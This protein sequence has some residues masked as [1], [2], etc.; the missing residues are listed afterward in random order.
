MTHEQTPEQ[1]PRDRDPDPDTGPVRA[2][3]AALG[4]ARMPDD[5]AARI[6]A[7]LAGEHVTGIPAGRSPDRPVPPV[8]DRPAAAARP[9][10]P[11][12]VPPPGRA[13]RTR[14]GRGPA[15]AARPAGRP[16]R[17]AARA[18]AALLAAA[19]A[20]VL[21]ALPVDVRGPAPAGTTGP[22][23]DEL[24]AAAAGAGEPQGPL[25]DPVRRRGCLLAAGVAA[26]D[27]PLLAARP[28]PVAGR[29][30][31]LLVLGTP[32]R[33]EFRLVV[34]DPGCGPGRGVLLAE[35]PAGA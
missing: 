13:R 9:A 29:P 32:R 25:A 6:R 7:R 11:A 22:L 27:A 33:G 21:L 34:V 28:H 1:A 8:P 30:G 5:V 2:A 24:R 15:G 23:A 19:A 18:G 20:V 12:A 17:R 35:L 10:T 31:V 26:P 14:R 16:A 3:L 4:P